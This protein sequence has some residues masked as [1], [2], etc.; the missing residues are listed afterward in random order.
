MCLDVTSVTAIEA[1]KIK[2]FLLV[3]MDFSLHNLPNFCHYVNSVDALI[4]FSYLLCKERNGYLPATIR[5]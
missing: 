4:T 1:L 3:E 2:S 5:Q